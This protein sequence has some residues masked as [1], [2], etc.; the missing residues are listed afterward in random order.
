MATTFIQDSLPDVIN[1]ENMNLPLHV[2]CEIARYIESACEGSRMVPQLYGNILSNLNTLVVAM[3]GCERIVSTPIPRNYSIHLKQSVYIYLLILPWCILELHPIMVVMVEMITSFL[4][5]GIE[6][7]GVEIENP[8]G[9]DRNDLP[10]DSFCHSLRQELALILRYY[11]RA[12]TSNT[13][14]P[15]DDDLLVI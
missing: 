2:M 7:I 9:Y 12:G 13:Q 10:L 8:F 1:D 3:A 11:I 6:G 4:L 5:I 14:I 15:V